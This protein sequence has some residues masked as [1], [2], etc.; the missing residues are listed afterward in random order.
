LTI[1]ATSSN[2]GLIPNP[3]V[4]YASPN[5]TG[6]LTF[7]PVANTNG[8][9]TINVTVNDGQAA[10]NTISRSFTVNV[11]AVNDAPTITAIP[12][13]T[14]AT[15]SST[16]ALPFTIGD[17]ETPANNLTVRATSSAPTLIPTNNIVFGGSGNNRTVRLTSLPSQ[18]SGTANITIT[19][20]DGGGATAS[21]TFQVTV[22]TAPQ[23]PG[24]FQILTTGEGSGSVLNTNGLSLTLGQTYWVTAIPDPGNE[25]A[26]W[27]G[28]IVLSSPTSPT[29]SFVMASNLVLVAS[30]IPSPA[31]TPSVATAGSYNGLFYEASQVRQTSAGFLAM[32]VTTKGTYS[33]KLQLGASRYSISG[34]LD[35]QGRATNAVTGKKSPTTLTV[36]IKVGNTNQADRVVGRITDGTWVANLLGDRAVFSSKSNPSPQAGIYTLVVPGQDGNPALPQ[37]DG[38]GTA[39]VDLNGRVKFVGMLADG[40]KVSQSA[41]VS[42]DGVW[43]FYVPVYK[44][45]GLLMSWQTF[46]NRAS[47]DLNGAL[48]W[49]KGANSSAPYYAAGFASQHQAVGSVYRAPGRGASQVLNLTDGFLSFSGGNLPADFVNA[50]SLGLA[51]KPTNMSSNELTLSFSTSAGTFKGKVVDPTTGEVASFCGAV[52]QK[53]NAGY[54]FLLG[55]DRSSRV[56]LTP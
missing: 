36:E 39:R 41:P 7:T 56:A 35:S 40:T 34:Q 28:N 2:P 47:D 27:A 19:V 44:G 6:S 38:F 45:Q 52:L 10:N 26:G 11:G 3:T 17:A 14:I 33:G 18:S 5:T 37:G 16:A 29:T 42:Q 20:S 9:A 23:P 46:T 55:T 32:K 1:T 4:T 13:Q 31:S 15:N 49:I 53:M 51:G 12:D 25:F 54:G 21:T 30:F 8:S 48:T 43:P 24:N 50:I 22:Q